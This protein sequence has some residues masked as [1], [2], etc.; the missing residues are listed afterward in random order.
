MIAPRQD[1]RPGLALAAGWLGVLLGAAG[2]LGQP[3]SNATQPTLA[4]GECVTGSL[5]AFTA[6]GLQGSADSRWIDGSG[7]RPIQI[8]VSPLAPVAADQKLV[9]TAVASAFW[10]GEDIPLVWVD[11]TFLIP[12]GTPAGQQISF[13]V[14]VPPVP[15]WCKLS[16]DIVDPAGPTTI[17]HQPQ[18]LAADE[19]MLPGCPRVL[20]VGDALPPTMPLAA[21]F[22]L[23]DFPEDGAGMGIG[24][25]GMRVEGPERLTP[26]PL[27][28]ILAIPPAA[29]P[30]R[31]I[32]LT[33]FDVICLSVDR[34]AEL[35]KTNREAHRAVLRWAAAGGSL[36]VYGLPG[37]AGRWQRTAE[38]ERL[39]DL[40]AGPVQPASQQT[41]TGWNWPRL[42][43]EY[44]ANPLGPIDAGDVVAGGVGAEG[45]LSVLNALEKSAPREEPPF[46]LREYGSGVVVAMGTAD[47]FTGDAAWIEFQWM[48]LLRSAMNAYIPW[49]TR[50]GL[51]VGEASADFWNFLVPGVGLAPVVEFQ[52]LITLFVLLIGPVNY[53]LLRRKKRLHLM[54]LSVPA[55]ALVVTGLLFAYALL[56]DGLSTRVR[57]RTLTLLDQRRDEA[58]T[59]ARLSYYAGL[60]PSGGLTFSDATAV[61]PIAPAFDARSTPGAG[62]RM[63]WDPDQRLVQG[64]LP[65][66]TPTQYL[67]VRAAPTKRELKIT[68][69]LGSDGA[70][71]IENLLGAPLNRLAVRT[72]DGAYYWVANVGEGA[73]IRAN[74][75]ASSEVLGWLNTA[76]MENQPAFPPGMDRNWRQFQGRRYR[77]RG[78]P[79][80]ADGTGNLDTSRL[81]QMMRRL[82]LL[83]S[84]PSGDD[85]PSGVALFEPSAPLLAP[86]CYVAIVPRTP[87]VELGAQAAREEESFH[88]I[89]GQW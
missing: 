10:Q 78:M 12:A 15:S 53:W 39:L 34:L 60:A 19:R 48:W 59:W 62:R 49:Q 25:V 21:C 37:D 41:P 35:A 31:W 47:P 68:P 84:P 1:A 28:T 61:Y 71:E 45:A 20:F 63:T 73:S 40:P 85:V 42:L 67:T 38:L 76:V 16:L 4:R 81:E 57:A 54:V 65:P 33:S 52:V 50:H 56:S 64:W 17:L 29:M 79:V 2:C 82:A 30:K 77:Y 22:G 72:P 27:P 70:I 87:E 86:G 6:A 7:Y 11:E 43:T 80:S 46:L 24:G 75:A 32:E 51:E 44:N 74:K 13:L 58:V 88:V 9:V 89:V 66:R 3:P 26:A 55:S 23:F 83:G 69:V 5:D 8:R 14:L 18:I 36:W